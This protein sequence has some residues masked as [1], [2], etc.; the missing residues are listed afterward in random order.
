VI[1]VQPAMFGVA[2]FICFSYCHHGETITRG[3]DL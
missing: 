1:R 2:P 3:R